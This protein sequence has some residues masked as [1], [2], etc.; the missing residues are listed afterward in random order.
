MSQK[1]GNNSQ[2]IQAQGNVNIGLSYTDVK[3]IVYDLFEQN[4]PKLVEEAKNSAKQNVDSYTQILEKNLKAKIDSIDLNKFKDPNTQF[5]LNSSIRIAARKGN[6][7]DLDLLS[8]TLI[9]SLRNNNT[10]MLNIVSEQALEALPKLTARQINI[11]SIVQYLLHMRLQNLHDYSQAEPNNK[12]IL[13]I[14]KEIDN[15]ETLN[16]QYLSSLGIATFNQFQGI[17]PYEAIKRQ[18]EYL[19]KDKSVSEVEKIITEKS[20]SMKI[21]ADKYKE[22][23]LRYLSLTPTGVLIALINLRRVFRNIDYT[24]W[25]K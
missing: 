11:L 10:E 5:L 15:E 24:I 6:K 9:S 8:E 13:E 4:F 12:I 21:M 20:P 14:T 3:K 23:N 25:I 16:M 1:I 19:F 22:L 2:A 18:Y 7:V 17:N